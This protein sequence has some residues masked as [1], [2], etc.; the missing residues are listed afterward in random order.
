MKPNCGRANEILLLSWIVFVGLLPEVVRSAQ[1]EDCVPVPYPT[2]SHLQLVR[3]FFT[4]SNGL[5]ADDVQAVTVTRD[6][7]VLAAAGDALARLEGERWSKQNGP[8]GVS[9]LFAPIQG[10]NALAGA[11]NGIWALNQAE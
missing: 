8:S 10:P 11:S 9:A 4:S 2:G 5:P 7:I 1:A 6:G 3:S